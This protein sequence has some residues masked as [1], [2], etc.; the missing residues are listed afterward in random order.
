MTCWKLGRKCLKEPPDGYYGFVYCITRIDTG[1]IYIGKK[2]FTHRK[3]TKLSKRARKATGKRV[4]I[5]TKDSG[6]L[7]Y[8]GSSV[9][10]KEEVDKVGKSKYKREILYLCSNKAELTF[11]EG[12]AMYDHRVFFV[13]SYNKWFSIKCFKSG[14]ITEK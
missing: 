3:K 4:S 12:K 8:Y 2:A 13:D 14:G 5:G 1:R 7:D 11:Y 10:L 6:W 9:E